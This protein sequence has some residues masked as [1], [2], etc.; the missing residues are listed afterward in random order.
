VIAAAIGYAAFFFFSRVRA[1]FTRSESSSFAFCSF[2]LRVALRFFPARL[3]KKVSILIPEAGPLG[4]TL[5][6][7]R[8]RAMVSG[9]LVNNPSEGCVESV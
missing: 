5:F 9:S 3:M 1:A 2:A 4:E 8:D 7:A 6:D